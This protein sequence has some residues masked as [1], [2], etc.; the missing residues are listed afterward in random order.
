MSIYKGTFEASTI[1]VDENGESIKPYYDKIVLDSYLNTIFKE[2][3]SKYVKDYTYE[4][5]YTNNGFYCSEECRSVKVTLIADINYFY[6]Y[7]KSKIF[8]V[9]SKEELWTKN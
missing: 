1:S 3:L 6:K 5:C 8:T 7:E 9:I 4:V 2:N